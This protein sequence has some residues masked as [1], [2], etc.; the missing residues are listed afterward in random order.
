MVTHEETGL[1]SPVEESEQMFKHLLRLME[2]R[3]LRK[4]IGE[5]ARRWAI[6]QW[7]THTLMQR[8][9]DVYSSVINQHLVTKGGE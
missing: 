3:D 4:R 6:Q 7:S 9:M 8:T 2:D 1:I 5:Q